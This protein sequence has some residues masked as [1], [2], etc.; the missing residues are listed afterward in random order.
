MRGDRLRELRENKKM[1][2]DDL[3]KKMNVSKSAI[4]MYERNEREPNDETLLKM[5]AFFDCTTDF[6]L[7]NSDDPRLTAMEERVIGDEF[8]E[9]MDI[10]NSLTKEEKEK[11]K[12]RILAYAKG[13]TDASKY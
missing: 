6:L 10:Y 3:A 8:K 2:Q 5:A 1:Y 11:F 7:G 9:L 4:G 12:E 13:M